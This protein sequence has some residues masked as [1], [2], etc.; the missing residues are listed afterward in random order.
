MAP[1]RTKLAEK[2]NPPASGILRSGKMPAGRRPLWMANCRLV[3]V[4]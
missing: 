1:I 4:S 3:S 2:A